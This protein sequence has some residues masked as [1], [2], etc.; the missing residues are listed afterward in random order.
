MAPRYILLA[1]TNYF[2]ILNCEI[3]FEFVI[4]HCSYYRAREC[5]G[6]F[7]IAATL[8]TSS[9]PA[10]LHHSLDVS[11]LFR[12]CCWIQG[13]RL[14]PLQP[15]WTGTSGWL[16]M[17]ITTCARRWLRLQWYTTSPMVATDPSGL[18]WQFYLRRMRM[19][20]TQF[21]QTNSSFVAC[22]VTGQGD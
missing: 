16:W 2:I 19:C 22:H 14:C 4:H 3:K 7:V 17:P 12:S 11:A 15:L 5:C 6:V 20:H 9:L 18:Y 8:I 13:Q 1:M 10:F 21:Y